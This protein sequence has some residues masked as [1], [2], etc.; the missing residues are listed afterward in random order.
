MKWNK[1][2]EA[3]LFILGIEWDEWGRGKLECRWRR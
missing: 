3:V 1:I 2:I